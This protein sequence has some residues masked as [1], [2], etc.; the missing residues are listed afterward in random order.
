MANQDLISSK[1]PVR[2]SI[3]SVEGKA[4]NSVS[5]FLAQVQSFGLSKA[6]RFEV[7]IV[8]P[9]SLV[10]SDFGS[11]VGMF[12]DTAFL[13]N[14]RVLTGRQQIFGP[15]E[16]FPVGIDYGGDNMG[17]NFILDREY[18]VK[19]YFDSWIN[20]IIKK[21]NNRPDDKGTLPNFVANYKNEYASIMYVKQ[22][23]EQD[24]VMYAVKFKDI[25]PVAVNVITLDHNLKDQPNRV[26]VT[27][28]YRYWESLNIDPVARENKPWSIWDIF[29][30][31]PSAPNESPS[32]QPGFDPFHS[33]TSPAYQGN[34]AYFVKR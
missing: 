27:F 1:I 26:N 13:P 14:V 7:V 15:P 5:N 25:F 34:N 3:N 28:N 17:I 22:L 21:T 11:Q 19:K 9:G 24:H 2:E 20:S 32:I 29:G 12:A 4:Q 16:F 33:A 10:N 6:N 23:D 31:I 18:Q 30:K 8:N